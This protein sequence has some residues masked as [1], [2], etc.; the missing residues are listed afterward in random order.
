M[1]AYQPVGSDGYAL[2]PNVP[3]S[4]AVGAACRHP[5]PH[6]TGRLLLASIL[7]FSTVPG[8]SGA[9]QKAF[10]G[11]ATV[12]AVE[13]PLQVTRGGEPVRGEDVRELRVF[14][15]LL[16]PRRDSRWRWNGPRGRAD[17]AALDLAAS[18]LPATG[19]RCRRTNLRIR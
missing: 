6:Y 3:D 9:E 14:R 10:E 7:L 19:S 2:Q 15:D 4:S 5:T 11:T 18:D 8:T 16:E 17:H 1:L 12:V 13:V